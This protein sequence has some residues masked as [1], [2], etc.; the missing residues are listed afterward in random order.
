MESIK[1]VQ[2]GSQIWMAEN[3]NVSELSNGDVIKEAQSDL[4]WAECDANG[5][6]AWCYYDKDDGSNF[7]V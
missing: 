1:E 7:L 6:P 2:I 5:V 3:L 4:D